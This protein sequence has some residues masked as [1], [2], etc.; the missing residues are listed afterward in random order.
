[1]ALSIDEA[2]TLKKT[3]SA[4]QQA[5]PGAVWNSVTGFATWADAVNFANLNPAQGAG[6]FVASHNTDGTVD[7]AYFF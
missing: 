2:R 6:E 1:M 7:G 3:R 5:Q 4:A